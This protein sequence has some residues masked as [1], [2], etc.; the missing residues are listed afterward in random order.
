MAGRDYFLAGD[1]L[2]PLQMLYVLYLLLGR[3]E[4]LALHAGVRVI[5]IIEKSATVRNVLEL[6]TAV[7]EAAT[8]RTV[9]VAVISTK[10]LLDT[11]VVHDGDEETLLHF[12]ILFLQLFHM[13]EQCNH[14]FNRPQVEAECHRWVQC[15]SIDSPVLAA[16]ECVYFLL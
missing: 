13:L 6:H 12:L 15:L 14:I 5:N 4:W 9:R 1:L 16:T 3:V 7:L 11:V 8:V 2:Q 10:F